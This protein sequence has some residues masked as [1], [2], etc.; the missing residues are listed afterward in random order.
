MRV[1]VC[2][3]RKERERQGEVSRGDE[4]SGTREKAKRGVEGR[5]GGWERRRRGSVGDGG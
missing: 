3:R 2:A 4:G 1:F 5:S